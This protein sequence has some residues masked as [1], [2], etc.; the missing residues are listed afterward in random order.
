MRIWSQATQKTFRKFKKNVVEYKK[1]YFKI[2]N[3]KTASHIKTD[4]GSLASN[5]MLFLINIKQ[6]LEILVKG[7]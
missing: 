6:F 7:V 5:H 3:N 2:W 1:K 4:C